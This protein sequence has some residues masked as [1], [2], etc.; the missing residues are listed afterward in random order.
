M[1]HGRMVGVLTTLGVLAEMVAPSPAR[2]EV[3]N[4]PVSKN[5][6]PTYGTEHLPAPSQ[7][8]ARVWST[9]TYGN[10]T[11]VGGEFTSLAPTT[12]LAGAIDGQSGAPQPGFPKVDSGQVN[13]AA[14]DGRGGWYVGG[15]FPTLSNTQVNGL[16]H[17]LADGTLDA[18]FQPAIVGPQN[19]PSKSFTVTALAL[20]GSWLYVGGEFTKFGARGNTKAQPRNHIARVSPTTGTIDADWNPDAGN[21]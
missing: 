15:S 10:T 21:N 4:I 7:F 6:A 13:V 16:A 5:P 19:Q 11:Y 9:A 17:I 2:A 1:R 14:P 20:S 3:L 18:N 8:S 12:A